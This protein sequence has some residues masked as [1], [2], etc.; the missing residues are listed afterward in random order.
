MK[1]IKY[2]QSLAL[3]ILLAGALFREHQGAE[4]KDVDEDTDDRLT[5]KYKETFDSDPKDNY[6]IAL[7]KEDTRRGK[8]FKLGIISSHYDLSN[9]DNQLLLNDVLRGDKGKVASIVATGEIVD[10]FINSPFYAQNNTINGQEVAVPEEE[11]AAIEGE[12]VKTDKPNP[13]EK[14]EHEFEPV[15]PEPIEPPTQAPNEVPEKGP[16][17]A[18]APQE[19]KPSEPTE[20]KE[21]GKQAAKTTPKKNSASDSK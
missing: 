6:A 21:E 2:N 16:Q 9:F 7:A 18:A 4:I 15:N 11:D 20:T 10:R 8:L 3:S 19:E 14:K 17:P 1:T 13:L 12:E 5:R